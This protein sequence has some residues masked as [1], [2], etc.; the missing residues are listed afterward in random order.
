MI[1]C[2]HEIPKDDN[3]QQILQVGDP[4]LLNLAKKL[5]GQLSGREEKEVKIISKIDFHL[6]FCNIRCH[7]MCMSLSKLTR[8][9]MWGRKDRKKTHQKT[10]TECQSWMP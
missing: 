1:P 9:K 10:W 6:K 8:V 2:T 5:Y 3:Q 4:Q 7:S